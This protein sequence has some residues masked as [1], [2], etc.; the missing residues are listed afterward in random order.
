MRKIAALATL[1][2]AL[3]SCNLAP[4]YQRPFMPVPDHFKETGKWV[5]VKI[6]PPQGTP[7]PWWLVF[8]DRT[9][10]ELE[11]NIIPAN[12]DLKAA[13]ARYQEAS[14]LAQVARAA[15]FPTIEAISNASRQKTSVTMA[16]PSTM[17]IY[18]NYLLGA[19]LDYEIDVWGSVRNAVK[20]GKALAKASEADLAAATLSL[21][22]ALA[23]N[24][25]SLRAADESQRILDTTVV[26]YQK[27]LYLTKQRHKGGAAPI[28]DVDEAETQL[29]NAKTMAADIRLQRAQLEHAIAILIGK[30]P[31]D[32]S[33][34]P[35]KLPRDYISV[36]PDLPSTLLE[37]RPDIVAAELR[38]EAANA[39]IGIAR[40]A[41]FPQFNL[42]GILGVQSKTLSNLFSKP[43]LFWA[44]GPATS[45]SLIQPTASMILFDG[46]KL[47]GLLRQAN[48]SYF[49]TVANYRQ[50]VL[51][52]VQEVEDYLVAIR[53]LDKEKRTAIAATKAAQRALVQSKYRYIGGV[54][55]FLE[56]VVVEN[57]ALQTELAEVNIRLRRQ[58][59]SVQLIKALGGG[60]FITPPDKPKAH[61]HKQKSL[62]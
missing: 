38:V 21:H 42:S 46:G 36:S 3:N 54:I 45:L 11:E 50:T 41:F 61:Q 28:A 22:A 39:N 43:S 29:E 7:G 60:W 53:Q 59:A 51:T 31:A 4:T 55:T 13:F 8:H 9:L 35:G 2:F 20:Q 27:A 48:A 19:D 6:A 40:A 44:I 57:T 18:N 37:R 56:V 14:A 17:P 30:F 52:A 33:L 12:Q 32:F 15:L 26:A 58:T 62:S 34:P 16:N 47:S 5:P 10:N 1:A 49:E 25:F 24:Y 23:N